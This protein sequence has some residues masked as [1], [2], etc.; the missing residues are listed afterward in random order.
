MSGNKL[1]VETIILPILN[2]VFICSVVNL[3]FLSVIHI[4]VS[5]F[6]SSPTDGL[7]EISAKNHY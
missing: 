1:T 5:V 6:Y 3:G 4:Y 7:T 2:E